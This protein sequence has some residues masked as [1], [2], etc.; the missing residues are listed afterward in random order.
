MTLCHQ[1]LLRMKNVS[2][3]SCREK[4]KYA[5]YVQQ[6]FFSESSVV[7]EMMLKN[8][9]A[10][11]MAPARGILDKQGYMHASTCLHAYTHSPIRQHPHT[12]ECTHTYACLLPHACV[13]ACAY[14]HARAHTHTHTQKYVIPHFHSNSG[15]V[16]ITQCYV[17]YSACLVAVHEVISD[18]IFCKYFTRF[19]TS[20]G[21]VSSCFPS[22]IRNSKI[23]IICHPFIFACLLHCNLHSSPRQQ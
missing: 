2:N 7:Y 18:R 23:Y 9:A 6:V 11:N 17:I 10:D 22:R 20:L 21:L 1:F 14:A 8:E 16:N 5:F 19:I 3:K 4:S 15:F 12:H 13:R